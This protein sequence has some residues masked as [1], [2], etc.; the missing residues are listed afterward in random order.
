M[1]ART[2]KTPGEKREARGMGH[3]RDA[4]RANRRFVLHKNFNIREKRK[5]P[6]GHR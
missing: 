3:G 6:S 1:R 4:H 2:Y 5:K